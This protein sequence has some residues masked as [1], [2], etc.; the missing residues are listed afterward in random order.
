MKHRWENQSDVTDVLC[1]GITPKHS[2]LPQT[3]CV[4]LLPCQALLQAPVKDA[5][6]SLFAMLSIPGPSGGFQAILIPRGPSSVG[7]ELFIAAPQV[8]AS[9]AYTNPALPQATSQG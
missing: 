9:Q 8:Q 7:A 5:A 4:P 3:T 6:G 2:Y 1:N